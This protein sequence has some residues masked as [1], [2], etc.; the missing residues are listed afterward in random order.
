MIKQFAQS[1]VVQVS[2][3]VRRNWNDLSNKRDQNC[4]E[5][6]GAEI[7]AQNWY[8]SH[9]NKFNLSLVAV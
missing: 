8:A 9:E 7:S 2:F 6:F 4:A 5:I 1:L 3:F